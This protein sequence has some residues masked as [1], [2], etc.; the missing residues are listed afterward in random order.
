MLFLLRPKFSWLSLL[1]LTKTI[2]PLFSFVESIHSKAFESI[3]R[4][5]KAFYFALAKSTSDNWAIK[6]LHRFSLRLMISCHTYDHMLL[7]YYYSIK[8][9]RLFEWDRFHFSIVASFL[10]EDIDVCNKANILFFFFIHLWV[11]CNKGDHDASSTGS[12]SGGHRLLLVEITRHKQFENV[13][14]KATKKGIGKGVLPH[15][16]NPPKETSFIFLSRI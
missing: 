14:H 1:I 2:F 5:S 15:T 4:H 9:T 12:T 8:E 16:R 13:H 6:S 11:V 7:V 3:R 10:L